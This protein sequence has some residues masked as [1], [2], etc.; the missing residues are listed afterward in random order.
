MP[1]PLVK[2]PIVTELKSIVETKLAMPCSFVH[3][4]LFEANFGL[5]RM[6]KDTEISFPVCVHVSNGKSDNELLETHDVKRKAKVFL[7]LL[8]RYDAP[9]K[10]YS[11]VDV[12]AIIYQMHQLSDN[13]AYWIN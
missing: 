11:S 13:L 3:A 10:D 9:T 6:S 2:D 12:N 4:N 8:N 5:D 1:I 7:L